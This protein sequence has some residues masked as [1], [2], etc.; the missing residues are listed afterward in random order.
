VPGTADPGHLAQTLTDDRA[1]SG[2]YR[3]EL[4]SQDSRI[5]HG[6]VSVRPERL[7]DDGDFLLSLYASTRRPEL[8][9]LGWSEKEQ[10]A[11]IGMQ[12]DAQTGHYREAFPNATYTVICVD[13]EQAGR[14]IVNRADDKI[15]IV[16]ITLAPEFRR[17]DV[18][19]G[20]AR[21]RLAHRQ[22]ADENIVR[23]ELGRH[24][25]RRA[26]AASLAHPNGRNVANAPQPRVA[27]G[28]GAGSRAPVPRSS[29][30][31]QSGDPAIAG[32]RTW[33]LRPIFPQACE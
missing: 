32:R 16:D 20:L 21:R 9:G 6:E 7:P 11:F 30:G 14:L 13:G 8:A 17:I 19:S 23:H 4:L 28:L 18:G 1:L 3:L 10:D 29:Y 12:F 15:V 25:S 26:S 2:R 22:S 31:P 24:R 5:M 33:I 27:I